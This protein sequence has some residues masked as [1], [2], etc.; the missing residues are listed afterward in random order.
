MSLC[1]KLY[2]LFLWCVLGN[3]NSGCVRVGLTL[4]LQQRNYYYYYKWDCDSFLLD[5]EEKLIWIIYL[6]NL[7]LS[8]IITNH[9]LIIPKYIWGI[10]FWDVCSHD[11][12]S[13]CRCPTISSTGGSQHTWD[14]QCVCQSD[15]SK[16]TRKTFQVQSE[17]AMSHSRV[18]LN[19][20]K[21][22]QLLHYTLVFHLYSDSS[23][24]FTVRPDYL[25]MASVSIPVSLVMCYWKII[26][27]LAS[28][29]VS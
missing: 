3:R 11:T 18:S 10:V 7:F 29:E 1:R 14:D 13:S 25:K 28:L 2:F 16:W 20:W 19:F 15:M 5:S 23:N 17:S 4:K 6:C 8:S 9:L 26:Q 12:L 27:M 24:C 22:F 21:L